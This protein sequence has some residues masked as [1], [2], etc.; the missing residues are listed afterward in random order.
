[1]ALLPSIRRLLRLCNREHRL[2]LVRLR[3]LRH[4]ERELLRLPRKNEKFP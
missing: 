1:M 4:K 3:L 2:L